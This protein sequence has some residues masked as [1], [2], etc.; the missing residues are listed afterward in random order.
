VDAASTEG[1]LDMSVLLVACLS[2]LTLLAYQFLSGLVF[3]YLQG[4]KGDASSRPAIGIIE[5]RSLAWT[6]L[7]LD[8]AAGLSLLMS[9]IGYVFFRT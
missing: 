6:K 9:V 5:L 4:K 1:I 2:A 8:M 3:V 7:A